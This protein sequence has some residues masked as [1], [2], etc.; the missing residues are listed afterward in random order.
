MTQ[1]HQGQAPA[2]PPPPAHRRQ[3]LLPSSARESPPDS[4]PPTSHMRPPRPLPLRPLSADYAVMD[5]HASMRFQ[6]MEA[7]VRLG[8]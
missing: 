4:L 3:P 6:F 2:A 8:G 7:V 1:A 5:E